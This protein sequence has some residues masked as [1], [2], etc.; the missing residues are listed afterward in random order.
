[1]SAVAVRA[2]P[3]RVSARA[4][5][6][7]AGLGL[8]VLAA[9]WLSAGA[10][11][12]TY[13]IDI[14][15]SVPGWVLGP[16]HAAGVGLGPLRFGWL[17]LALLLGWGLAVAAAEELPARAVWGAVLVAQLAAT[18]GPTIVSSDLFGYL[19]YA[20]LEVLHGLSPYAFAP[21][22]A[23]HDALLGLVYWR[24]ATSPYGP[25]FTVLTLPLGLLAPAAA[26]WVFKGAT[27]LCSVGLTVLCA[28]VAQR[29]GLAVRRTAIFVGLNPVLLVYAVSGAH[30]DLPA[31]L[32][33]A[34]G[35]LA[36]TERREGLGAALIV[37]AAAIKLPVVILLPFVVLG[38]RHWRRAAAG[39]AIAATLTV[40]GA[41]AAFGPGLLSQLGRIASGT[42]YD[43]A[44]GGPARVAGLAGT[45]ITPGLR[46]GCLVL[47]A[48]VA[49][50]LL[51]R[52]RRGGDVLAAGAWAV[53]ALLAAIASLAP[54]YLVWLLVPA[55][56]ARRA[57]PRYAAAGATVY[58][59]LLH[60]PLLGATPWLHGP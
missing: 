59:L 40:A 30:N 47:A 57:A 31:M 19:S 50:L 55:A 52:A 35:L 36:V 28:R 42:R 12:G 22:A 56:L 4:L 33:V 20:R 13:L 21:A 1:M 25:L 8:V 18:L 5:T 11:Q 27:G 44:G 34:G 6:G 24:G 15:G 58:M 7:G 60:E 38:S 32:L 17:L 3:A 48:V 37:L 9:V 2:P 53:L 41:V 49:L 10:A 39:A 26:A 14:P 16:L 51:W 29:R 45:A 54:W 43:V 23:P 46:A